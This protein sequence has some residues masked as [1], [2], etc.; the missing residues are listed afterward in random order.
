MRERTDAPRVEWLEPERAMIDESG[1]LGANQLA[2]WRERGF[3]L[4]DGVWPEETIVRARADALERFPAPNSPEATA[5]TDFGSTG[6]M[7]F[8]AESAVVNEIALHPRLLAVMG[9]LLGV[10]AAEL[11]LTQA[12]LWPKYGRAG[13][14]RG[15]RDNDDQRIHVD[16]PN[17]TLTHPPRWEAPEAV[18]AILY[19]SDVSECGG[20]TAVVPRAGADDPAYPWPIVQTPGVGALPWLNDRSSAEAMLRDVAPE[21]A[22]WRREHLYARECHVRSRVGTLLLYRHDTWHR[23][24]PLDPGTL[25][26]AMNLTFR[27]AAS[28]WISVLQ[29]GWAWAMYRPSQRMERLVAESSVEQRCVLGFPAPGHPYWTAETVAAVEAR[30]GLLGM[31]LGPYRAALC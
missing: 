21:V 20:A 9:G 2:S 4:V 29:S 31:D 8:P 5:I 18:E 27:K 28:E 23:G 22:A 10:P 12:D 16:Y 26:L 1:R 17:H 19:L 7:A 13:Q 3:V 11:R 24:T 30:Y 15:E 25:R 14:A 6:R